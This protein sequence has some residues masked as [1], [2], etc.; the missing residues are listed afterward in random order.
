MREWDSQYGQVGDNAI[1]CMS[2]LIRVNQID[3]DLTQYASS[4][5]GSTRDIPNKVQRSEEWIRL[6]SDSYLSLRL[7]YF[8]LICLGRYG[9]KIEF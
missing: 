7:L 3:L 8:F 2:T 9:D 5:S 6:S 1:L 4:T